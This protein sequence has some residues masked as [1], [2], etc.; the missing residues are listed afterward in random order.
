MLLHKRNKNYNESRNK[1]SLASLVIST[2]NQTQDR[3]RIDI[4]HHDM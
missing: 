4:Y 1:Y 2:M 3:C